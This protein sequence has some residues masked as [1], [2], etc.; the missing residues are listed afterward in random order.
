MSNLSK[1]FGDTLAVDDLSFTVDPGRIVG[2]LGPNGAGKTTTLRALLGLIRPSAGSATIEGVAYVDLAE[3]TATV[4]AVLDGGSLHP[5]RS[6]RNHLRSLA[7]AAGV[8]DARADELLTLV[9]L[10]DAADRRAGSYSL[11]MRQR[12]GLATAL[13]GD[14]RVLILDEPANGLDPQGI[15]W[16]R[17]FLRGLAGE[18]RAILVSSHVLAEVAQ[19]ADDVVVI[20]RGRSVAQATMAELMAQRG[21]GVR[22]AGP[23]TARLTELLEA[24]GASV[25]P[26]TDGAILVA[27]RTG[28]QVGRVIAEHAVVVS[29]LTPAGQSL[30]DV[31]FELTGS[32][33]EGPS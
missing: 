17:D 18:G 21:D 10:G 24:G 7:A 12:L 3:P 13:L 28:E 31:F 20:H 8:S 26:G 32:G 2:F 19:T 33:E 16:L 14:P 4:G 30:E 23:D 11:G 22:V 6:G 29:E 15:R 25:Q 5:G 1:R 27:D 9:S